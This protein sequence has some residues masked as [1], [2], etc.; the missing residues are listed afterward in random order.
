MQDTDWFI[1][2]PLNLNTSNKVNYT[3]MD[4]VIEFKEI[5]G[6]SVLQDAITE[7]DEERLIKLIQS[8]EWSN[9]PGKRQVQ[10]YGR[11]Y[12]Y[13]TRSLGGF[14]QIPKWLLKTADFLDLPIPENIIINKYEPGEGIS[15]H[16]DNPCF[17]D[18]VASLS[19]VSATT[20]DL[21]FNAIEHGIRL[22]P[23]SLLKL[24]GEARTRWTHGIV[25]RKSD[26]V[27]GEKISR[28][29]RYSITFRTL[30]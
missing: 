26:I 28:G 5:P 9:A 6:L 15:S 12:D 2:D 23:R 1:V 16:T 27:N 22:E 7:E 29:L 4:M 25:N 21:K 17:G 14:K 13:N 18:L 24:T 10:Q 30:A 3:G 8:G 20:M 19:L 11:L